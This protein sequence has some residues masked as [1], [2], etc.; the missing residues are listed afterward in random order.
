MAFL[1]HGNDIII[2]THLSCIMQGKAH[3]SCI[4]SPLV[5]NVAYSQK[6]W[7]LGT[8]LNTLYTMTQG[9][10]LGLVA[11]KKLVVFPIWLVF[12]L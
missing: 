8:R 2:Q 12:G 5:L 9:L 6:N 4:I 1:E 3:L 11:A 10:K 7:S